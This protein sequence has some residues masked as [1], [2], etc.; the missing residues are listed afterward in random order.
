MCNLFNL[1]FKAR[2]GTKI[3]LVDM[4]DLLFGA[5]GQRSNRGRLHSAQTLLTRARCCIHVVTIKIQQLASTLI[6]NGAPNQSLRMTRWYISSLDQVACGPCHSFS[7]HLYERLGAEL[8][9]RDGMTMKSGF[10][11][12]LVAACEGEI[13]FST[14]D[15]ESYCEKHVG[16]GV[17]MTWSYPIDDDG[18]HYLPRPSV[19]V[20]S[21]P[22]S[23][24]QKHRLPCIRSRISRFKRVAT[25][26]TSI[27]AL[28][29]LH[30]TSHSAA[31][32]ERIIQSPWERILSEACCEYKQSQHPPERY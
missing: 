31:P 11:A 19:L 16:G 22:Y 5:Q 26:C 3:S 2:K 14:Y 8:G 6:S 25:L 15:G 13:E 28:H 32:H 10:C 23:L 27:V 30:V 18:E 12:E 9:D 21:L 4:S 24:K 20:Y 17:D 29:Q 1:T 7:G